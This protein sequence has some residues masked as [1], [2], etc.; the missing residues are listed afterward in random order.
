MTAI[1]LNDGKGKK[2]LETQ[3]LLQQKYKV[4]RAQTNAFAM[5]MEKNANSVSYLQWKN[6]HDFLRNTVKEKDELKRIMDQKKQRALFSWDKM[7][8]WQEILPLKVGMN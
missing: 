4:V 6:W 5:R 8:E 1:R 7:E 3:S 2:Y